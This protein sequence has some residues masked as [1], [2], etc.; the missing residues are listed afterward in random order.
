MNKGLF[1]IKDFRTLLLGQTIAVLGDWF[2][3]IA[4]IALAG[5]RWQV[6]PF[7]MSMVVFSLAAPML[8][9]GPLGGVIADRV[10]RGKMMS[11][12]CVLRVFILLAIANVSSFDILIMLL[13]TLGAFDA[14][15]LPA[16][17]AK[18]KELP[19]DELIDEAVIY[20][21]FIDQGARVFGPAMGGLVLSSFSI[22]ISLYLN[23]GFY[24][25]AAL[26]FSSLA[27]RKGKMFEQKEQTGFW[28]EFRDGLEL[29][30]K[31]PF[32]M[33]GALIQIF[34]VLVLQIV[35][36]QFV[37]LLRDMSGSSESWVGYCLM[38]SGLGTVL[39][40][41]F[42]LK[43]NKNLDVKKSMSWGT[44]VYSL[45]V[46]GISAWGMFGNWP[47]GFLPFFVL[48]GAS[49]ALIFVK[50]TAYIQANIPVDYSGR[51]FGSL[52]SMLSVASMIGLLCGGLFVS[53]FGAANA[54]MIAGLVMFFGSI[55]LSLKIF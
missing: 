49:G 28:I 32:I 33:Q 41:Y 14:A 37:I 23:A 15:F 42:Y 13:V 24:V 51:V 26:I 8:F 35:D 39:M 34:V 54:F 18:I 10:D 16:K 36:S 44:V 43:R 40:T 17:N 30:R 3:I 11:L 25:L 45:S 4:V 29:M 2:G 27:A 50:Y 6:T 22:E 38:A 47:Q 5:F 7:E 52:S 53:L 46:I 31:V 12:I 9:A 21:S 55:W 19:P 48:W 1:A 20:S